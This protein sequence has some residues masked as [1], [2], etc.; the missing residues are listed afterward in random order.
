[1][2]CLVLWLLRTAIHLALGSGGGVEINF[3]RADIQ[4]VAKTLQFGARFRPSQPCTADTLHSRQGRCLSL[5]RRQ[6][7]APTVTAV[8]RVDAEAG[9]NCPPSSSDLESGL[10]TTWWFPGNQSMADAPAGLVPTPIIWAMAPKTH[11]K[12]ERAVARI[13]QRR[14]T[15]RSLAAGGSRS[16]RVMAGCCPLGIQRPE[17][18]RPN[19]DDAEPL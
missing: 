4:A 18:H 7:P 1:M 15:A 13:F 6:G 16:R 9:K 5:D 11:Y 3:E 2:L 8:A 17:P 10:A 19:G 14:D 12:H